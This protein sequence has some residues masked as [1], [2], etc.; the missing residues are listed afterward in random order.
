MLA[1]LGVSTTLLALAPIFARFAGRQRI[2]RAFS[3]FLLVS[4]IAGIFTIVYTLNWLFYAHSDNPMQQGSVNPATPM[5]LFLVQA[6][7][8]VIGT[9]TI[10]SQ[11]IID[12]L[13][14]RRRRIVVT[15]QNTH[16]GT[17]DPTERRNLQ[18]LLTQRLLIFLAVSSILFLSFVNIDPRQY[19]ILAKG[20]PVIGLIV[21]LIGLT[22]FWFKKN[23]LN[24]ID[25]PPNGCRKFIKGRWVGIYLSIAFCAIWGISI[26]QVF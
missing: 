24:Q 11:T 1:L 26:A 20:L 21:T 6:I 25:R 7:T 17:N 22:H 16:A 15:Q 23:D 18:T 9:V 2:Q 10:W 14:T 19:E 8:F 12:L 13:S 5:T 3:P 4:F